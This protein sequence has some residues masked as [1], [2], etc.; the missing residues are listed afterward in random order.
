MNQ[1]LNYSAH[2][3][4]D[5]T[6]HAAILRR[7]GNV[8]DAEGMES[9]M[10][11]VRSG[12]KFMLPDRGSLIYDIDDV[13]GGVEI[14]RLPFPIT[15]IEVPFSTHENMAPGMVASTKRLI[16]AREG[17]WDEAKE[18]FRPLTPEDGFEPN[19]IN[20]EIACF[21]PSENVWALQPV[22]ALCII[23]S[24]SSTDMPVD[25]GIYE[26][27]KFGGASFP[28]IAMPTQPNHA[29]QMW[30]QLGADMFQQTVA[31]DVSAEIRMMAEMLTVLSCRNVGTETLTPP[32]KLAR[33]R[34]KSG[35]EPFS[36]V[37]VLTVGGDRMVSATETGDQGDGFKVR[38][39]VRRGHVRNLANGDR[40]RVNRAVIAAGS[41]RGE[42]DKAY[43]V[44]GFRS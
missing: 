11:N 24:A 16:V 19:S 21:L 35:K 10:R 38:Q 39:H 40:T 36:D 26:A 13:P 25:S 42:V 37:L 9:F 29:E 8:R 30:R 20:V 44:E 32:A 1:L 22:G 27:D 31:H 28:L 2:A 12:V 4:T 3:I 7:K 41:P 14:T 17:L 23:G 18:T 34:I 15:V 33:A 6:R 5:I 43:Q